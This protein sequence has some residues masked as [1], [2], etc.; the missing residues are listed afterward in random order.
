MFLGGA[1]LGDLVASFSRVEYVGRIPLSRP[2]MV[3]SGLY[4]FQ[5]VRERPLTNQ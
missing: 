1:L 5:I 4:V 2:G 3:Y